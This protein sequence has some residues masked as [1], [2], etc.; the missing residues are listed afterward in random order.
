MTQSSESYLFLFYICE[1]FMR[2]YIE[3]EIDDKYKIFVIFEE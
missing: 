3:A 2:K 1:N